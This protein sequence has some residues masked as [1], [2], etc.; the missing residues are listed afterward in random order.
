MIFFCINRERSNCT[1]WWWLSSPLSPLHWSQ[2]RTYH[3]FHIVL[4]H[5]CNQPH[6]PNSSPLHSKTW[7]PLSDP[8]LTDALHNRIGH[9]VVGLPCI[10][11]PTWD[12]GE[13]H[14]V[15]QLWA[16]LPRQ[17][18]QIQSCL[19]FGS[20]TSSKGGL[21]LI[22]QKSIFQYLKLM[23]QPVSNII[24]LFLHWFPHFHPYELVNYVLYGIITN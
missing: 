10:T 6:I 3:Y 24:F 13:H 4:L 20:C 19:C 18:I 12:T 7:E 17:F 21:T 22:L 11:T 5:V 16:H 2:Q 1:D 14:K 15:T 8:G 23:Q 9:S